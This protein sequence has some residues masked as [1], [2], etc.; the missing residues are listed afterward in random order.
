[1]RIRIKIKIRIP[2]TRMFENLTPLYPLAFPFLLVLFRMLGIFLFAPFFSN[3]AIPQNVRVLL[4]LA[5]TFCVWT[6]V[7]HTTALPTSLIAVTVAVAG[8]MTVGLLIGMLLAAVFAG[9]QLGAHMVSQQM[10]LSLA[11]IYSPGF[12]DQS[13]IMEQVAFWIALVIFLSIGGHRQIIS[14][15]VYSYKTVPMGGGG[16]APDIM[17]SSLCGA[18]DASFHAAIRIAMPALVAFFVA[19]LTAGL[20]SRSMPQMNLMTMGISIN[21]VVGF[22]MVSLGLTAWALVSQQSFQELAHVLEKLF[23]L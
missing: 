21:L 20:M 10:G 9:I 5:I 1:M 8:E 6:V 15:I 7:P 23:A 13:T 14:A 16:I 12:E 17:L 4:G 22:A 18:M 2:R 11:T 19:T 3:S